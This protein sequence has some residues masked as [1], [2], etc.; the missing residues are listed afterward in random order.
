MALGDSRFDKAVLTRER[1]A[2]G[3]AWLPAGALALHCGMRSRR[4][5]VRIG[6]FAAAV[7]VATADRSIAAQ[8]P[9]P[10]TLLADVLKARSEWRLLDPATD[11]VGDYTVAQLVELDRWPPW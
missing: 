6:V 11:L 4:P 1:R 3:I 8:A 7:L 5:L 9:S 10:P 2:P